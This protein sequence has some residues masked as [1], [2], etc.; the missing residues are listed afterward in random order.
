MR[1]NKYYVGIALFIALFLTCTLSEVTAQNNKAKEQKKP[2]FIELE[3]NV[4]NEKGQAI[5]NAT[6]TVGEGALTYFTDKDGKCKVKVKVGSVIVIE[7]NG[8]ELKLV[9]ALK[10][11]A[12]NNKIV[13]QK[14]ALFSGLN[15]KINL[16]GWLENTK[17]NNVG[18]ISSIKGTDIE[19]YSDMLVGNALQGK[20]LGLMSIMNE[21]GLANNASSLYIRGLHRESGNGIITLVDG[22]ERDINTLI[23]EEIE[24]IE[25]LKDATSKILYGPRA[26]NGV[27]LITTK[28]GEKHKR[29][30]KVNT[31]Y[32]V[33]I[34]ASL[35]KFVNSYDYTRLYNEARQNDGLQPLYSPT[36]IEGYRNSTGANDFRYP[37]VD[38]YNYFL[39]SQ[40]TYRKTNFEF[41][42]G[43]ENAQY[44]FIAGYNGTSG[45]QSVGNTPQRDRFNVRGNLDMKVTDNIAAFIGISGI[46]DV[47]SRSGLDHSQTFAA[48]STLRPNEYPLIIPDNYVKPDSAGFP[49]L[50]AGLSSP[51]NLY[52]SLMYGGYQ[53]DQNIN[54]QL[55]FGLKFDLKG[56]TKGLKAMAQ[57]TF[58]NYFYGSEGISTSAPTYSQ[59]W[60]QTPDGRDSVI[61]NLRKK[62]D[63][64]DNITL[65]NSNTYRTSSIMA[66]LNYA[67]KFDSDNQLSADYVYN[68]YL[69]EATG[70]NQDLKFI[71]NV[72]RVNFVNQQKYIAEAS[73]GY[74]GSN[75]FQGDN[76]FTSSFSAGFGWILS[77]ENFLKDNKII[78]F[79]KFKVSAGQ[80]AYDGQMPYNTYRDRWNDNSTVRINNAL[81]PALTNFAQVGNPNLKWEK[82]QEINVGFEALLFNKKLSVEANYFNE[83]RSDI[84]QKNSTLNSALL[85][86]LFPYTNWGKVNNQGVEL[87]VNYSDRIGDLFYELGA[88]VIYTKN[89]L[90]QIDELNYPDK[91]LLRINQSSD[92][93]IGYVAEGLFGKDVDLATHTPQSFG[94][95]QIGDIA[96]KNLNNDN[97]INELDRQLLS[98]S[99]PRTQLSFDLN[100]KYKGFG[101]YVLATSELGFSNWLNNSYYWIKSE[102]KYSE[103]ALNRYNPTENPTGTYPRLTTTDG[104]NNFRNSTFWLEAGD[105]L[106][107]KNIELSYNIKQNKIDFARNI[108]IFARG[109]NLVQFS[110][111]KDHDPEAI[112]AGLTNYPVL[113]NITGGL[114]ITF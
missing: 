10:N 41:S 96:Y 100:L 84:I 98:N 52:G 5:A 104:T 82:S 1:N 13:M 48:L 21:G 55:N 16:P 58:D 105:F 15:D 31:E 91:G 18:A 6:V 26:A 90:L 101:L 71:N 32:G 25:V 93:M 73:V 62:S 43:N 17:R 27:L 64:N 22:V 88:N 63:K 99:F 61:L 2:Q 4:S 111:A 24:S 39:N 44:A 65:R 102:G 108:K 9:N 33:G 87:D 110:K 70:E 23:P 28:R 14:T 79:L 112:N 103:L 46:F 69:A 89:K 59:R 78:D 36:D 47:T 76:Q 77:E 81:T 40:T 94:Q 12:Y 85:G 57:V 45:L 7:A 80:L 29:I 53:K 66:S 109:T 92:V 51:D 74:M 75:K 106:R 37:N 68:Y 72:L 97:Y 38:Y 20:L 3:A 11:F 86:G 19:S 56:I 114:S 67:N 95:Y 34:A 50:G 8:Y 60:M 30:I 49:S 54:G 107:I 35:P 83:L 113:K 42:G